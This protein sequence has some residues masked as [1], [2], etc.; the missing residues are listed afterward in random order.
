[1]D[2][3]LFKLL[4]ERFGD[5]FTSLDSEQIGPGSSFMDQFELRKK[6]FSCKTP[7]RRAHRIPLHMP[8]LKQIPNLYKYYEKR[9]SSVLLTHEDY[10][11]LFHPVVNMI[12]GLINEQVS[13]IKAKVEKAIE[14]IVLVSGFGSSPYL[15]ETISE[16]CRARDIRL[17]TTIS[18]P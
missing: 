11:S 12:L 3:N 8:L 10:K 9:S 6:D 5:P 13:Q 1:M 16:C 15:R 14:T 2:R 18:G 7:S 17:T 4:G